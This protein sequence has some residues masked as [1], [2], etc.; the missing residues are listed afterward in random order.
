MWVKDA[1]PEITRDLRKR[2]LLYKSEQA[3]SI[4]IRSAG[5]AARR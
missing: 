4:P 5:A 2:G 1:D 3:T